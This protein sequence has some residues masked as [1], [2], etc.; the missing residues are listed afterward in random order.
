MEKRILNQ[1]AILALI[2]VGV[3]CGANEPADESA[4]EIEEIALHEN[5]EE[6]GPCEGADMDEEVTEETQEEGSNHFTSFE[7]GLYLSDP[8][9]EAPTNVRDEPNGKVIFKLD[10]ED[11]MLDII[12]GQNGWLKVNRISSEMTDYLEDGETGW[13]HSSVCAGNLRNYDGR[14]VEIYEG[15]NTEAPV[16]YTI[17]DMEAFV[18]VI[19]GSGDYVKIKYEK[20]GKKYEGWLKADMVCGNPYTSCS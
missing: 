10:E 13:I 7:V 1:W 17:K 15:P 11:I 19:D 12:G 20:D 14:E 16:V 5:Y 9:T 6:I 18:R 8:D 3:S 4:E 2:F